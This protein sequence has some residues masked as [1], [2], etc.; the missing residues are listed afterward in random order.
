VA[1]NAPSQPDRN[2][3][4]FPSQAK[5][6]QLVIQDARAIGQRREHINDMF[7][8]IVT[9]SLGAQAYL[10]V[11]NRDSDIRSLLL[12]IL[13]GAFGSA[14]CAIWSNVLKNY[15]AL[16]KFRY[17]T[18][19]TWEEEGFPENQRYYVAEDVIYDSRLSARAPRHKHHSSSESLTAESPVLLPLAQ[20]YVQGLKGKHIPDFVDIYV[21]IPRLAFIAMVGIVVVRIVLFGVPYVLQYGTKY[22]VF[23]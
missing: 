21:L 3:P 5:H 14:L 2:S 19:K 6:Y 16:L 8:S 17:T 11:T 13:I 4:Q 12:I 9:L 22:H 18:L 15:A 10:I 7:L 1:D 23:G 20:A